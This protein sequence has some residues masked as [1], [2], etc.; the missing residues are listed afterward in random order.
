VL[1]N[2]L[3]IRPGLPAVD[4]L[5]G[6]A[7]GIAGGRP[8]GQ[9]DFSLAFSATGLGA[10]VSGARR[11]ESTLEL[12]Q[13]ETVGVLRF[14]PLLTMNLTGFVEATRLFPRVTALKA[15]DSPFRLP[16]SPTRASV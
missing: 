10:R 9:V 1:S 7:I 5:D 6:G 11:S 4:L 8:R 12:R 15:A 13:G 16:I 2:E 14:D 3:V